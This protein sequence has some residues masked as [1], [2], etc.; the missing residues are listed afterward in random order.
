MSDDSPDELKQQQREVERAKAALEVEKA[1]SDFERAQSEMAK[2]HERK[3]LRRP[4]GAQGRADDRGG[5]PS[6]LS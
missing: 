6:R 5:D 2:I 3:M 1:R 4:T